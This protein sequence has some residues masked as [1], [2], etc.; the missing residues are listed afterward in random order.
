MSQSITNESSANH[1]IK[2][3]FINNS[4]VGPFIGLVLLI[5]V[6]SLSS[7]YF[8]SLRNALNIIDQVTVLGILALGMTA[9][10]ISGGIDLSVGSIL[11]FSMMF[12]GWLERS[13]GV[14][15]GMAM[16]L[17]ILSGGVCGLISGLMISKAKLP[18]FIATLAMMS[19]ARGLANILTDGRQV[20]GYADWFTSLSTI[21]YFGVFTITMGIF[22]SL[23]IIAAI[24]L[25]YR[26]SGRNIYAIG[27]NPVVARLSG[28]NVQKNIISVYVISGLLSG[29]A[30]MTLAARLDSSQPSAGI[31]YE[32]DTIAAVVIGG[33]SLQGGKGTIVGTLVGV[34]IIGVLRNGLNL[35]GVSPFFQQIVIGIVIAIAVAFDTLGRKSK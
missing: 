5:I 14:P 23:T 25:K 29:I 4:A 7:E 9:V 21:R 32:L 15:L 24:I 28:I 34:L 16:M 31:A 33:A 17:G 20:V 10:I 22:I 6:F 2:N 3:I 19:I 13:L 30:A 27:G 12:M 26:V 1:N 35:L 18:A 11:A 8:F